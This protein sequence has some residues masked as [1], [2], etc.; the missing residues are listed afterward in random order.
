MSAT[1]AQAV[2][3]NWGTYISPTSYLFDSTG[4]EL[5][6]DYYFELGTFGSSFVP[7]EANMS[8]WASN[9]K[10][11][12]RAA[13]PGTEGWN[14]S[15]GIVAHSATLETDFTTSNTN[16]SQANTFATGEQAYIWIY[17]GVSGDS[18]PGPVL[19]SG[20]EWALVTND[21]S[22]GDPGDDWLMPV[23][24]GHVA[25][26]L[27]WRIEDATSTPFGG[28]NDDSGPGETSGDPSTSYILQTHTSVAAVPEPGSAF[29]I[30]LAGFTLLVRHRRFRRV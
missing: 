29:F 3:I 19:E 13:A 2:T 15:A 24:S 16:L 23:P 20:F 26:S 11:F 25:T 22:D 9:W 8:E 28:L 1:S 21:S 5:T 4:A 12:D 30:G 14:S 7:T 18:S 17:K 6:D 27:D 10:V